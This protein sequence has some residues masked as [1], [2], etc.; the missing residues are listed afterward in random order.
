MRTAKCTDCNTV[1]NLDGLE[2]ETL[3]H[4]NE[5]HQQ[6]T[7]CSGKVKARE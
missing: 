4:W 1:L 6:V 2:N 7:G 5:K 3:Q